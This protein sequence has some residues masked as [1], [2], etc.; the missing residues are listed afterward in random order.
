VLAAGDR[1]ALVQAVDRA[2]A[3][4][5]PVT[6]FDSGLDS[7]NYTSYVAT[8]NVEAGRIGAR[9]L[10]ALLGGKGKIGLVRHVPGSVSTTDRE[11]GFLEVIKREYPG[12]TIAQ[13][14]YGMSDPAKSRAVAENILTAHSDL[15]GFF[16]STEPSATGTILALKSRGASGKVK[17]VGFDSNDAMIEDMRG[18]TLQAMVVQDPFKI[19][20]EAVKSIADTIAGRPVSKRQDLPAFLV[21]PQNLDQPATQAL[22]KPDLDK[23]RR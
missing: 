13:E 11:N 2:M 20:Y 18:G 1:K 19:G 17:L 22:L 16:A 5:I 12:I 4:G 7:S 23:P 10:A 9:A 3:Q 15:A 6:I 21:T 8:D 14:A